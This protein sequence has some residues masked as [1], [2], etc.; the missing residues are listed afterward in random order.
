MSTAITVVAPA[1][2]AAS[3][4]ERPTAP[5]PKSTKLEPGFGLS[6]LNTAPA[7]VRTPQ[8]SG[9]RMSSGAG[10]TEVAHGEVGAVGGV[11]GVAAGAGT[12]AGE[13]EHDA[14]AG[15]DAGDRGA[16]LLHDARALV[17]EYRRKRRGVP[18]VAHDRVGV[19]DTG[20]D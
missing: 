8:P 18:L 10:A 14:V 6:T 20:G 2:T 15:R 12:A 4:P 17:A 16:D 5:V 3:R 13:A 19:T 9:P 7:P 11:A 1:A